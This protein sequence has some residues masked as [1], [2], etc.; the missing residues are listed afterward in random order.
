MA[1]CGHSTEYY[2]TVFLHH[3]TKYYAT[4]LFI[5]SCQHIPLLHYPLVWSCSGMTPTKSA[6]DGLTIQLHF[7]FLQNMFVKI[8][9]NIPYLE[10]FMFNY[11]N[12]FTW[13]LRLLC[14]LMP[15]GPGPAIGL[16]SIFLLLRDSHGVFTDPD[17]G[18]SLP[19]PTLIVSVF[20]VG[21]LFFVHVWKQL[22]C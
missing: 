6:H 4:V 17:S 18:P 19:S 1:T 2:A 9:S 3:C 8:V 5:M 16:A 22:L 11:V 21:A 7:T 13:T 12:F 14:S 15:T 20:T 10:S